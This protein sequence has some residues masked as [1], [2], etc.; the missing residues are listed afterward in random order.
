MGLSDS[1][2]ETEARALSGREGM[3][4]RA[5]ME[6]LA[7]EAW[8]VLLVTEEGV[9]YMHPDAGGWEVWW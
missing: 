6:G 2:G 7:L 4:C 9:E 1:R 3:G 8:R 5:K